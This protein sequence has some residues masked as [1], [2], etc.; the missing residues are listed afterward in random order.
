MTKSMF[1]PIVA[2]GVV[3]VGLT[4]FAVPYFAGNRS[5]GV[6]ATL[7]LM[8]LFGALAVRTMISRA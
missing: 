8:V 7:L 2:G 5:I 6:A 3:M 1:P 4:A